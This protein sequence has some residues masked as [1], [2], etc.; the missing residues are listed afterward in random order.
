M[1]GTTNRIPMGKMLAIFLATLVFGNL[2]IAAVVYFFPDL[3]MP[4]S[5]GI[6]IAA[7]AAMAAGAPAGQATG[8]RMTAGEK[9]TFAAFATILAVLLVVAMAWG[10]LTYFGLPFTLQNS[11]GMFVGELVPEAEIR[12]IFPWVALFGVVVN[13]LIFFF[14][15]GFGA[16]NQIK[17]AERLAAKGK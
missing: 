14:G 13:F 17:Q 1:T 7:V 4:A 8:R 9:A 11:I 16:R 6:I 12:Q 2:L 3:N 15:V 10:T 5:V